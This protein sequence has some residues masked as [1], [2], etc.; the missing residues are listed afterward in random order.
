MDIEYNNDHNVYILGAGFSY[1][2]GYPLVRNFMDK[3]RE[4]ASWQKNHD[5]ETKEIEAVLKFRLEAAS[6]TYRIQ[7]DPENIEDLFSLSAAVDNTSRSTNRN[8]V[9]AIA[10]TLEYCRVNSIDKKVI[11]CGAPNPP[12]KGF[13]LDNQENPANITI[14]RFK[15]YVGLMAGVWGETPTPYKDN[16]F[17][18][19][20][21]DLLLEKALQEWEIPFR[22]DGLHDNKLSEDSLFATPTEYADSAKSIKKNAKKENAVSIL[23]PHGSVN[24]VLTSK[25]RTP[26]GRVIMVYG[27][28]CD[29]PIS[30]LNRGECWNPLD[31]LLAPPIWDKGTA[32][33]GHP[34]S[35]VWSNAIRKLQ[36]ATRIIVIGYSLPLADAHFRYLM[37]AGLQ[38]NISLREIVFV[39]PAFREGAPDK[40]ALEARIFSVFRRDL[41]Q[42]GILKLLPHT[43]HEFFHQQNIEEIL[44]RRYP[45]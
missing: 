7:F 19:F 37:A 18:T 11:L 21:Y 2:A 17:I 8:M 36:T 26:I 28:F 20:N 31:L 38:H 32:R 39:N 27:D 35:E 33:I 5:K 30:E 44:G 13:A 42:K 34:L 43:A 23:K 3:M 40:E 24:W 16:T 22:Y 29:I 45:F 1:E 10:E 6:A 14:N 4:A 12:P 9:I 15:L 41:H 25:A